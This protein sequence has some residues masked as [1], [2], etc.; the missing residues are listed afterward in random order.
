MMTALGNCLTDNR[1]HVDVARQV[2]VWSGNL[3]DDEDF[4]EAVKEILP[5][6]APPEN[7][8]ILERK[9]N[10]IEEK[11]FGGLSRQRKYSAYNS[12]TQN[13]AFS[14]NMPR[15][16]VRYRLKEIKVNLLGI[17][18]SKLSLTVTL[19]PHTRDRWPS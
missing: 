4:K 3:I 16:D 6:Y 12:A 13:A 15:F 7:P 14:V 18:G 9:S 5:I 19:D 2:R 1:L 17:P 11:E 10:K 8:S